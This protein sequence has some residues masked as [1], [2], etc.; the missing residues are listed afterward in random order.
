MSMFQHN[1]DALM[2]RYP[3]L[4]R[5][6]TPIPETAHLRLAHTET[7]VAWLSV[8]T[9]SGEVLLH[10]PD[11]P[12]G[13][14][15]SMAKSMANQGQGV[16]VILGLELGYLANAL[17]RRLT[18]ESAF[19]I[20][21]P[22][23][24][25]FYH[26]MMHTDLTSLI[27]TPTV[28]LV[29]GDPEG[30]GHWCSQFLA[31]TQKPL[32]VIS[33]PVMDRLISKAQRIKLDHEL[34]R[35]QG[36]AL[37]SLNAL[38]KRGSQFV[39]CVLENVPHILS[40]PGIQPL[41]GIAQD[42]PAVLIAA[43]PSLGK[44][45]HHLK[46][47]KGR[48][49]LIAADTAL[50]Y[51]L[52]RGIV[53]DFV[54]SADPQDTTYR[55]FEGLDIPQDVAL[56]FHPA[57]NH[58]IVK[59]FPG[60]KFVFDCAIPAYQWLRPFWPAKGPLEMESMCQVHIGF[61]LAEWLGCQ[62]I[63][64][65]GQ[66]LSYSDDGWHVRGGSYMTE[67]ESAMMVKHGQTV[68]NIFGKPVRTNP[69]FLNYKSILEKKI[70]QFSGKVVN[71]TEGGLPI[72]GTDLCRLQDALEALCRETKVDIP[73]AVKDCSLHVHDV[74]W[75]GLL[76]EVNA[77]KRDAF[78][79]TRTAGHVT[80]LLTRIQEK[81][82][83]SGAIDAELI[84]LGQRVERLTRLIPRYTQI[85]KLLHWIDISLERQLSADSRELGQCSD[86]ESR[87]DK[88]LERGLRYYRGLSQIAP[89]FQAIVTR[90]AKRLEL[91]KRWVDE[92]AEPQPREEDIPLL[93]QLMALD[94]FTHA[95]TTLDRMVTR[96][97]PNR[98]DRHTTF[99]SIRLP[100]ELHQLRLAKERL[101]SAGAAGLS[102]A[103]LET[104]ASRVQEEWDHWQ[105][106]LRSAQEMAPV[107]QESAIAAGD[108]YHRVGNHARAKYFYNKAIEEEGLIPDDAWEEFHIASTKRHAQRETKPSPLGGLEMPWKVG[109]TSQPRKIQV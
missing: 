80:R 5:L 6:L 23:P 3:A 90:L 92:C 26:A 36:I 97:N 52:T 41:R 99:L 14:A 100:L 82:R 7:G 31:Q 15:E 37:A 53:P 64:L 29:V 106:R 96:E 43:G 42:V 91:M 107:E 55:K 108:F 50:G 40:T 4:A 11:D 28:R 8:Q 63:I 60:P 83:A 69:T 39:E 1:L 86:V 81:R 18:D 98:G 88:E 72:E 89:V 102:D 71:A 105:A 77:R 84:R 65:V 17:V 46:R 13:V 10:S 35:R 85:R 66:D 67:Q 47:T 27:K 2:P 49:V 57:C 109:A 32:R 95:R 20:Y 74:E 38:T 75:T 44:N 48:A 9:E 19:I 24:G 16:L 87:R 76:K 61:N 104:M 34:A 51:L 12:I 62:T 79:I 33:S 93:D 103:E 45:V 78:R 101:K 56:V 25:V 21:E 68:P 58:Q 94:F 59:H 22:D 73:A 30:V 54:V 70:A